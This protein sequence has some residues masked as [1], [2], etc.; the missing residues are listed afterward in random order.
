A[1]QADGNWK[2]QC[3]SKETAWACNVGN[4]LLAL[5]EDAA[6]RDAFAYDQMLCTPML[7]RLLFAQEPDFTP[8]PLNDCD[9]T[10]V[11]E[12]LQGHGLR[13][14][15]KDTIFQAITTRA[16]ECAFHPIRDY[17][18]GLKWDDKPRLATWLAKYLGAVQTG[19][20]AKIGT[21]FLISMV[22]RIFEPGC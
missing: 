21:M 22:A 10:R 5:R 19:Y 3:M 9:V 13:R 18:N 4:T 8:R 7:M 15:G 17:L 12:F 20:V 2:G 11:Q 16:D 6:L 1:E 14:L